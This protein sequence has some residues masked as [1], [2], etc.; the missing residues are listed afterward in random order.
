MMD[1]EMLRKLVWEEML[2]ADMRANYFAELLRDYQT[3]DKWLR[4]AV[5]VASSGAVGT[6][7]SVLVYRAEGP[8]SSLASTSTRA[9]D[10]NNSGLLLLS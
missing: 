6:T 2:C 7:L 3:R 9:E 4:V 5:L 1:A 10:W 8:K